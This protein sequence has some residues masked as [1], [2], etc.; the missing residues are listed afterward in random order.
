VL[1][2]EGRRTVAKAMTIKLLIVKLHSSHNRHSND[3]VALGEQS[4]TKINENI[5][6][7]Y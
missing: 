1:G 4:W 5:L 2:G 6:E 3:S 7:I